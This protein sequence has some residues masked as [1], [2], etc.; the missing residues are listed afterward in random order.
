[1]KKLLILLLILPSYSYAENIQEEAQR[2]HKV[3][4]SEC[5][6]D[7]ASQGNQSM[8]CDEMCSHYEE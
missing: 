1:M 8:V 2:P 3:V 6:A 5:Y 4:D 7:C